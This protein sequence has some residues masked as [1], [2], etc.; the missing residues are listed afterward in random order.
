LGIVVTNSSW[1]I[2]VGDFIKIGSVV[3]L[4]CGGIKMSVN[5]RPTEDYW[6]CQWFSGNELRQ[7][8]FAAV[9]LVIVES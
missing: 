9:Q 5:S 2:F 7:A 4:S 1:S 8:V 3:Q 6:L